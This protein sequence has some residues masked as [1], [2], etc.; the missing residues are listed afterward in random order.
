[1]KKYLFLV[2]LGLAGCSTTPP[3]PTPVTPVVG[4][5]PVVPST[6]PY[7]FIQLETSVL[8]S[9]TYSA[10]SVDHKLIFINYVHDLI[11]VLSG[12]NGKTSPLPADL[13]AQLL[14]S[15]PGAGQFVVKI[16]IAG[17]VAVYHTQYTKYAGN[18]VALNSTLNAINA[19]LISGIQASTIA[20][21]YFT[22]PTQ[23]PTGHGHHPVRT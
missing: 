20:P 1:M 11:T 13:E 7:A 3:S 10:L 14:K 21:V 12:L 8:T 4:P 9:T 16:V 19:G 15:I 18:N 2:L 22:M 5:V 23:P 6:G 17:I